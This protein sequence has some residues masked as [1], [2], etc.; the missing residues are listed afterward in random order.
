MTHNQRV[1]LGSILLYSSPALG[2]GFSFFLITTYFMKYGT[3]VLLIAP[4]TLSLMFA[5]ARI[6]DAVTDP[7]V[8]YL[9]DRTVSRLGRR[10]FWILLSAIPLALSFYML[11]NPS[12]ELSSTQLSIW[13]GASVIAYYTAY[14]LF[15]V[16]H[17]A[18]GAELSLDHHDRTR[19]FGIK[20][21]VSTIGSFLALG[22]LYLFSVSDNPRETALV[23]SLGV[24]VFMMISVI[25]PVLKLPER[26]EYQQRGENSI[27]KAF[28]DVF[29]NPHARLV[30]TVFFIEN[31]GTAVIAT[32][33][34]YVLEYIVKRPDLL[35]WFFLL[36]VLPAVITVPL[37]IWLSRLIGKK[38][39]WCA[40][41]FAMSLGF[42]GLFFAREGDHIL[43]FILAAIAGMGGGCGN[44]VGPSIQA[45]II[46]YDEWQTGQRKEGAYFAVWNFVRKAAFGIMIVITGLVLQYSGFEPNVEQAE[47][48][49]MAMSSLF[50]LFPGAC[51][52][53]GATLFLRFNLDER[54]WRSIRDTM[55]G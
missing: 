1:P 13:V 2:V 55:R 7:V 47:S 45:D 12:A 46:D 39:L 6:W 11:W 8:G 34:A 32:L 22:A 20:H 54:A 21:A 43:V 17:E 30:V 51:Y 44:V 5:A 41:M 25:P 19:V 4:A 40:S 28:G 23:I 50:G 27:F 33:S 3:D 48:T 37:W 18:W 10:R 31:L 52:L 14:S 15:Y 24:A 16:P 29:R 38:Q 49:K 36:Y 35:P 42:G 53:I 9:S 26:P